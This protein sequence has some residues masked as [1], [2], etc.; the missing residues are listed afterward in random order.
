MRIAAIDIGTNSIHMVIAEIAENGGFEVVD[1]EREVVQVGRGSFIANRLQKTAIRRTVDALQRFVQLA[2]RHQVDRILCTAT[3]AVRE[4]RNGGEFIAAARRASGIT[5]RVIPATEEGRLIY[6]AVKSALPLDER[7]ALIVDIGG[8]SMQLVVGN[9]DRCLQALTMPLGA[10]RLSETVQR[11]DPPDRRD[12]QRLSRLVRK[13]ARDSLETVNDMK[14]VRVYGS[15]GSIHALA[16]VAH[17]SETGQTIEH[18]N[19]HVLSLDSL[20]QASRRLRRMTVDERERLPGL[21]AKRAGIIVPGAHVLIHVLRGVGAKAITI[22]D[23]GVRE[24]LVTDFIASHAREISELGGVGDLRL[25]SVLRCLEKFQP[26]TEHPVHVARLAIELFD[27]LQAF[28]GLDASD[29]EILHFAALLHDVGSVIGHD[30]H[31]EHAYYII[32][33]ANL[34]GL[35]A[36]E[37]ELIANVAR[38]HGKGRPRKRD[39]NFRALSRSER[40]SVR[41]LAAMLRIAEGLDR[42]QYQLIRSLRV[43]K[44]RG[45]AAIFVT[46]ATARDGARLEIW[47]AKGRTDLLERMIGAP[48]RLASERPREAQRRRK[49]EGSIA[50][51]IGSRPRAP[52][53]LAAKRPRVVRFPLPARSSA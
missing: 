31:A 10:L 1:R 2:R 50:R 20:E 30:R 49:L 18:I 27:G 11:S 3:A 9:R 16:Q 17:W 24:G 22:S 23:Y 14:P 42:S 25:R 13:A 6:L 47:A 39:K 21:D 26:E 51:R 36:G 8:G 7:P 37:L 12:L 35:T 15:S 4:A 34:R 5:P 40:K 44:H 28:H 32:K 43:S 48:I 19:G 41:W 38:Y 33:N 52:V 46:P 45:H 29:R 53:K